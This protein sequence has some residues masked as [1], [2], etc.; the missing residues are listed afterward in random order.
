VTVVL[1][2]QVE[3]RKGVAGNCN[4]RESAYFIAHFTVLPEWLIEKLYRRITTACCLGWVVKE[5]D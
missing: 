2:F 1:N 5:S 3:Q 4:F